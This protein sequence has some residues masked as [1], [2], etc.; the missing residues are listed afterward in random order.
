MLKRQRV[1]HDVEQEFLEFKDFCPNAAAIEL[2]TLASKMTS[3]QVAE[4]RVNNL[5]MCALN[6]QMMIVACIKRR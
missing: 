6:A 3:G 5:A 1:Q 4:A 2:D